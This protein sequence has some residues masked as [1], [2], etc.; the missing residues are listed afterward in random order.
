MPPD[1]D[2]QQ[3]IEQLEKRYAEHSQ[4]LVFAHLADA[5][6]RAGEYGKAEGLIL[7]GLKNHPKYISAYNVLG[8]VYIDSERYADAHEQ[9][10]KVLELDPQ[11]MIA[12]KAL[13]DLALRGG[14]LEDARS[15]F[16]RILQVDP[17]NEEVQ[18]ELQRLT[19]SGVSAPAEPPEALSAA[20]PEPTEPAEGAEPEIPE[21]PAAEQEP[22]WEMGG[23]PEGQE[24]EAVEF[25]A[26]P[27][28]GLVGK[29]QQVELGDEVE[30]AEASPLET[31]EEPPELEG[32]DALDDL[33]AAEPPRPGIDLGEM[34]DWTPGL[35]R[36]E[37]MEGQAGE[38][39]GVSSLRDEF[40]GGEAEAPTSEPLGDEGVE[41]E[42]EGAGPA[43]EGMLTETMA[44]LYADQGL[45]EDALGVYR[46][47][48]KKQP[49][50][51]RLKARIA[52]LEQQLA[53]A[54]AEPEADDLA[55]LLELTDIAPP[56][57][58][59]FPD[60]SEVP[61]EPPTAEELLSFEAPLSFEETAPPGEETQPPAGILDA[62]SVE[63]AEPA[64]SPLDAAAAT[65]EEAPP[66]VGFNFED[67][68][69][70]AGMDHLDPFAA[71]FDAMVRRGDAAP[72]PAGVGGLG[73]LARGEP[74]E[75]PPETPEPELEI[76]P[77]IDETP[78]D[79]DVAPAP[80]VL[81]P[82]ADVAP[83]PEALPSEPELPLP[84][85]PAPV[86]EAPTPAAQPPAPAPPA[87]QPSGAPTIEE[88]LSGLLAYE[89]GGQNADPATGSQATAP[90]AD[91]GGADSAA[92]A[93]AD[94][95]SE[96]LEQF[97]EWLRSLK[98]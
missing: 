45:Y 54:R 57:E 5:Y 16:E 94:S 35:L 93:A 37:D 70:V 69:P 83:A 61:E 68:A 21:F 14:R 55:A 18:E 47:L 86:A 22:P 43:V 38:D 31:P 76:V 3:E 6:R 29:G 85:A 49:A 11:N 17:R 19:E 60:G 39:L 52:E 71:S 80:D 66:T 74:T 32:L 40:G 73:D 25:S 10:S 9:F 81:P 58:E 27:V 82:G 8:R 33:A 46:E 7:H 56:D 67:E 79:P 90:P 1:N 50:D 87:A 98:E 59:A 24:E 63:T 92:D 53:E 97:Q 95:S 30:S 12:M 65:P 36:E 89:Q 78:P 96:D 42:L 84:E 23:I 44:E 88:Y 64:A 48:A 20:P 51:E 91:P 77:T 13:G 15:W 72:M 34:D 2:V 41:A 26:E 4:G 62:P 75:A 28:E